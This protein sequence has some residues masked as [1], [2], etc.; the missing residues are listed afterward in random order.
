MTLSLPTPDPRQPRASSGYLCP[1]HVRRALS[2]LCYL[3]KL[4][5]SCLLISSH[6]PHEAPL[7]SSAHTGHPLK[8]PE[9]SPGSHTVRPLG[10]HTRTAL[11]AFSG[12]VQSP[13]LD[14][15]LLQVSDCP[16]AV[17]FT[18][19]HTLGTEEEST[20]EI[21]DHRA[22][23]PEG[24][25]TCLALRLFGCHTGSPGI[26]DSLL[27]AMTCPKGIRA[28]RSPGRCH[29]SSCPSLRLSLDLLFKAPP[30]TRLSDINVAYAG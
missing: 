5:P 27:E 17:L 9:L 20:A 6:L 3:T 29:H 11:P 8:T 21:E 4:C 7:I 14:R 15:R 30:R 2:P 22:S 24:Q 18:C 26:T 19:P 13:Q 28:S 12:L 23:D 25:G 16:F 10:S 1:A